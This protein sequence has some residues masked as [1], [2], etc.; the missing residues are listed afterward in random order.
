MASV[1]LRSVVSFPETFGVNYIIKAL[2]IR[3]AIVRRID[4]MG[5]LDPVVDPLSWSAKGILSTEAQ[6]F[7]LMMFAGWK[8]L[9]GQ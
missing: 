1:A 3:D 8:A 4:S 5:V 9:I 6:A 2:K 7:T